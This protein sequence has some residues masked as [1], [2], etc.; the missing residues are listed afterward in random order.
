MANRISIRSPSR[1]AGGARRKVD[2]AVSFQNTTYTAVAAASIVDFGGAINFG[3]VS[4]SPFTIV[5]MRGLLSVVSDQLAAQEDQVGALGVIVTTL[6]STTSGTG[7]MPRPFTDPL[8]DW[9]LV[10][11]FKQRLEFGSAIGFESRSAQNYVLD[12]KAMRKV[13]S[14]SEES[15]GVLVENA[16]AHGIE[17]SVDLRLLIKFS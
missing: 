10:E 16:G 17:V 8:A 13:D 11:R 15:L 2:W 1:F 3:L 7:S 12:S 6:R 4:Q 9:M 14:P 5:R